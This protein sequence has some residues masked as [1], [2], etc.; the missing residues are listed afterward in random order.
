[1][2]MS[3]HLIQSF[4]KH[5]GVRGVHFYDSSGSQFFQWDEMFRLLED[6]DFPEVFGEKLVDA[7][8]NYDPD[9]E[10]IA[11]SAGQGQLTIEIFKAAAV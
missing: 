10:F 3:P 11:V 2:I 6:S 9:S 4:T 7:I 5:R 8:A 1:M